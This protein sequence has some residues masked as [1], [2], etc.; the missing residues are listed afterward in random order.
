MLRFL[1][2]A[3]LSASPALWARPPSCG[4]GCSPSSYICPQPSNE[5]YSEVIYEVN[6]PRWRMPLEASWGRGYLGVAPTYSWLDFDNPGQLKGTLIGAAAGYEQLWSTC[7]CWSLYLHLLGE[8]FWTTNELT[9]SP[10]QES[11]IQEYVGEAQLGVGWWSGCDAMCIGYIGF[12]YDNYQN[13]QDPATASLRYT[14]TKLYIPI[15]IKAIW[16][17]SDCWTI[18][19]EASFR[20]DVYANVELGEWLDEKIDFGHAYRLQLALSYAWHPQLYYGGCCASPVFFRADLMPF[21]DWSRFGKIK[22]PCGFSSSTLTRSMLGC[23]LSL[24][25][26]F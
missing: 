15:G 16:Q 23:R 21:F 24:S 18:T 11:S 3:F 13:C 2:L 4:T 14:F 7:D 12:G 20:P 25:L 10:C 8:G 9:G 26:L 5:P 19:P 1:L 17:L 6:G 22:D